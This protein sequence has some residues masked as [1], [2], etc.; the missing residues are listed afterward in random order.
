VDQGTML[1][2]LSYPIS[3]SEVVLGKFLGQTAIIGFATLFG[4]GIAG[5]IVAF[6]QEVP[7]GADGWLALATL[8]GSAIL[9]G[10]AFVGLGLMCSSFTR[11]RGAAA[12]LAVS[13]WLLFVIVFDLLLLGALVSGLDTMISEDAFPMLLLANPADVFRMLN[14]E[15]VA[16]SG[17]VSGLTEASANASI[18]SSALW[19]SLIIWS[20]SPLVAAVSFFK[21]SDL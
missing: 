20:V 15:L 12:G 3:R 14:M 11:Q 5:A 17:L 10:A 16:G 8:I 9:M 2:L 4:Y 19:L 7:P 18:A 1:L 13:L 21:R 6:S